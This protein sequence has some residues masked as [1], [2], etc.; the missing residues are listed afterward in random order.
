MWGAELLMLLSAA[1]P[2]EEAVRARA[3][4][5]LEPLCRGRCDV[6][7]VDIRTRPARRGAVAPG[8]EEG[9]ST[10]EV[11]EVRLT[12]LFDRALPADLRRF[13]QE[14][15]QARVGELARPVRVV[16]KVRAFP[17]PAEPLDAP[18]VESAP[19]VPAPASP[20][21]APIVIQP[22]AVSSPPEPVV[23]WWDRIGLRVLEVV[24][25]FLLFGLLAWV[26]LRVLRRMEDLVFDLRA[27]PSPPPPPTLVPEVVET[28]G[29]V[30]GPAQDLPPPTVEELADALAR[31][32]ASTRRVFRK[33][34]LSGQHDTVARAVALLGDGV[35]R[36]L[37]HDPSVKP[38]LL[39]ASVRTAEVLRA[40]MTDEDRDD[41]LR[42]VRAEWVADRVAHR[43]EDVRG[44]LEPL[45]GWSPEAFAR[46]TQDLDDTR[47]L[48]VLL[49]HAPGHLTE[50]FLRGLDGEAR[51]ELIRDVM[52]ALPATPDELA[53]MQR[54]IR[55]GADAAEVGGWEA[56]HLVELLDALPAEAQDGLLE[57]LEQDRPDFVR[58]N[59]GRLPV[60]SALLRVP[61]SALEVAWSDVPVDVWI[62]YLRSAPADIAARALEVCPARAR[63]A[64]RDELSLRVTVDLDEARHARKRILR[65][66]LS[67]AG[68]APA[69]PALELPAKL[70]ASFGPQA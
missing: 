4:A 14:R 60:E 58:R 68:R 61:E 29:A 41:L 49:R 43:S 8:F 55:D 59:A 50:A 32:R 47:A 31:H 22:P 66:A 12:V 11:A 1:V 54:R 26:V 53:D 27:P 37:S 56:D 63:A 10:L 64:V 36:D 19:S 48:H 21:P 5:A 65:S 67:A 40:P 52:G 20:Q 35:V 33:L 15:L 6:V 46:F 57:Q 70:E 69:A 28:S 2:S 13:A 39:E 17:R 18:P 30:V 44:E 9:V 38:H 24:P 45:L 62:A 51:T 7:E 16:P 23:T 34:L 25:L 42:R 3:R